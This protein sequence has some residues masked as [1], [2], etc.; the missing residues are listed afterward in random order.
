MRTVLSQNQRRFEGCNVAESEYKKLW[1]IDP[2]VTYLNHGSFGPSPIEVQETR[3]RWTDE[4]E[5]QPMEFFC[6]RMEKELDAASTR[7]GEFVG[8][9]AGNLLMV[10][11]ATVG[12]NIA[13]T[14]IDLQAG[15]EV[16]LTDHE[17]GAVQRIWKRKTMAVG[18]HVVTAELPSPLKTIDGIVNAIMN[19]V[20]DKTKVIVVSHVTSQTAAILPVAEICAAAR[21]RDVPVCI[22]GPHAIAMLPINLREIGCDFYMASC[23]KWLCGSFGSGFLYVHT[24]HQPRLKPVHTS[25]G[26]SIAGHEKHWKDDFNWIGT[27]DPAPVLSVPTA[28]NFMERI[29]LEKFREHGHSLAK[30]ALDRAVDEL[31]GTALLPDSPDWYGPMITIS[32]PTP[33]GWEP[34]LHG[35]ID[36]LQR[37]L[38]DEHRIEVPVFSWNGHRCLRVSAHL[39]N[40]ADDIDRLFESLQTAKDW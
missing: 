34:A 17:Y 33:P 8:A 15:D 2:N 36:T 24:R 37:A 7:L 22:D 32:I 19:R 18:A 29:G 6:Q 4:L 3:R 23:H 26:G 16:L 31:G 40:S 28:I 12:M 9:K 14:A 20:T 1:S 21:Q 13:A 35:K 30:L 27:R 39:Y 10:E 11:N 25:W 38:R 5:S